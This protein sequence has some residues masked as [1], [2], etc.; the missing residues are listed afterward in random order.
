MLTPMYVISI[1]HRRT[2]LWEFFTLCKSALDITKDFGPFWNWKT[3]Q[4]YG[5]VPIPE[6]QDIKMTLNYHRCHIIMSHLHQ[7]DNITTVL[8]AGMAHLCY[9]GNSDKTRPVPV[10]DS[11]PDSALPIT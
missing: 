11:S 4:P 9:Y 7:C 10:Q 1:K 3:T 6:A 5:G 8:P 2:S